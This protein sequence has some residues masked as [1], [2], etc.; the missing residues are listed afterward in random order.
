MKMENSEAGA[1]HDTLTSPSECDGKVVE[2]L[3]QWL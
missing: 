3:Q 2:D 1:S